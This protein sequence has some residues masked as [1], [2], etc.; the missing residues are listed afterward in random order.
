VNHDPFEQIDTELLSRATGGTQPA[1]CQVQ[2]PPA[3]CFKNP[4]FQ[5]I[6]NLGN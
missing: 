4:T 6:P 1:E 2:F 5:D 3:S